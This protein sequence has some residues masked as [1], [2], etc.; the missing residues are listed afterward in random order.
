MGKLTLESFPKHIQ[1][2]INDLNNWYYI[3]SPPILKCKYC[4]KDVEN[5]I[6]LWYGKNNEYMISFHAECCLPQLKP[7]EIDNSEYDIPNYEKFI[8]K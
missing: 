6:I 2:I 1:E 5:P 8:V 3:Y 4:Y 7:I